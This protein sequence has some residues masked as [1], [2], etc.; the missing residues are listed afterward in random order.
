MTWANRG[1]HYGSSGNLYPYDVRHDPSDRAFV[2]RNPD[3]RVRVRVHTEPGLT[4][5]VLV[6]GTDGH[7]MEVTAQSR[8]FS[9][10]EVIVAAP[11][12]GTLDYSFAFRDA[13]GVPVYSGQHGVANAMEG[14][15]PTFTVDL[16]ALTP[17]DVPDWVAG[18]VIYQV[19]P[20]RFAD[21]DPSLTPEPRTAT[22]RTCLLM[23]APGGKTKGGQG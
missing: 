4:E 21:G 10:W 17:I 23:T 20:D 5:A 9:Y 22:F 2:D 14:W 18:A 3:G 11:T 7:R 1:R 13:D 6:T 8:R 16:G 15:Q 19:F 12:D